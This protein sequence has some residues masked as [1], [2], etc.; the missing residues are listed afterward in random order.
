MGSVRL[1]SPSATIV[2]RMP[3]A[4]Q[5]RPAPR[6]RLD[7]GR[8]VYELALGV[9]DRLDAAQMDLWAAGVRSCLDAE[10]TTQRQQHLALELT[11]LSHTSTARRDGLSQ[12]I[13][14]ALTTLQLGL[15]SV[16]LPAQPLYDATRG[17]AEHLELHGGRRWLNRLRAV[18]QDLERVPGIRLQR[19]DLLL[20][21]MGPGAEGLPEGTAARISAVRGRLP[22]HQ[23][24]THE[25]HAAAAAIATLTFALRP[26]QPSRR[27]PHGPALAGAAG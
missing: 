5:T 21:K 11:R 9:A 10:G 26:P 17:L 1:P 14:R 25:G 20:E 7:E 4:N 19:L 22:R 8:G 12:D 2:A 3:A 16:D 13:A 27:M 23:V 18:V 15:G 6:T 24:D